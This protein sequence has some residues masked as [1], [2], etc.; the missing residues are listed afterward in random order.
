MMP[1]F[2]HNRRLEQD[3]IRQDFLSMEKY[4]ITRGKQGVATT[5]HLQPSHW[6]SKDG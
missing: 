6:F 3:R 5:W 1:V 4:L 2:R